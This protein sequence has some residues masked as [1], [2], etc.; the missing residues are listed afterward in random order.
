MDESTVDKPRTF[1]LMKE[2]NIASV[3]VSFSGGNDEGGA[4]GYV[5]YDNDGNEVDLPQSRA[6]E[7]QSYDPATRTYGASKWVV[8]GVGHELRDATPE[9]IAIAQLITLL[10]AP[11]Y[12]EYGGFD[13]DFSVSGEVTWDAKAGTVKMSK[14]EQRDYDHSEYDL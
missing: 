3:V 8:Y 13:G 12:A 6:H 7:N 9:E 14:D 4:D 11:I 2:Y 10:E 1:A 5:A